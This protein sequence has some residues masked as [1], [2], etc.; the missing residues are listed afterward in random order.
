MELIQ[1]IYAEAK[2]V[3]VKISVP[4]KN[5]KETKTET[6]NAVKKSMTT[7]KNDRAEEKHWDEKRKEKRE[8]QHK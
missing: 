3:C 1:L 6:G 8:K 4:L 2:L 7:L 5:T